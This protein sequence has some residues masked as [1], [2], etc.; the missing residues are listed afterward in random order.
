MLFSLKRNR[1]QVKMERIPEITWFQSSV[2]S[3]ERLP[4][5]LG[6]RDLEHCGI[7]LSKKQRVGGESR[8]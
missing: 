7:C 5:H 1:E 2:L 8:D 6:M 4:T 3:R